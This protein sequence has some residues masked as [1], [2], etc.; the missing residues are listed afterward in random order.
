MALGLDISDRKLRLVA[1][2]TKKNKAIIIGAS[3]IDLPAGLI[4][5]GEIVENDKVKTYLKKLIQA[6]RPKRRFGKE[7]IACLPERKSFIKVISMPDEE[8]NSKKVYHELKNHLPHQLNEVYIDWQKLNNDNTVLVG[9]STRNTVDS[10]LSVISSANLMPVVLEIESVAIARGLLPGSLTSSAPLII[11]DIGRARS[12]FILYDKNTIY[13]T[14]STKKF[15]GDL[16][17]QNIKKE[18]SVSEQE[19]DTLKQ[20]VGYDTKN[21]D[22]KIDK[23]MMEPANQLIKLIKQISTFYCQHYQNTHQIGKILLTGGGAKIPGLTSIIS[24]D[25]S[26][27]CKLIV[28]RVEIPSSIAKIVNKQTIYSYTTAIGL[29]LR[30][31]NDHD[32]S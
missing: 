10:Y 11:V 26:I 25:T 20:K 22:G 12:T 7:V 19:A 27:E 1:L 2:K 8:I 24:R 3:E 30:E 21:W 23:A 14:S 29:A 16:L 31:T 18:L 9:A 13:F 15:C 28:P 4:K 32:Y 5:D 6:T 17:T